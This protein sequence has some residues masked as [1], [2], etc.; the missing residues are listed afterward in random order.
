MCV[1]HINGRI[2]NPTGVKGCAQ[3][4]HF[5]V[6]NWM[7]A[8]SFLFLVATFFASTCLGSDQEGLPLPQRNKAFGVRCPPAMC[9]IPQGFLLN[10]RDQVFGIHFID[11]SRGWIVG[12][13]G[14]ALMTTDG[15]RSWQRKTISEGIFYDI[16]FIGE[17]GWIVGESGLIL[18]TNDGGESWHRQPCN[19]SLS[20]MCVRFLDRSKGFAVGADGTILRTVDGGLSWKI[21]DFDW[22]SFL[23]MELLDAG[24]LSI[25]LYDIIFINKT[26]GWIV[27]DSGT[28]LHSEDGGRKWRIAHVGL[29]P[30]LYSISF[31]N[32]KE[33]WAVGQNGFSL[34]TSDGGKTWKRVILEKENS[35][36]KIRMCQNYGIIVGDQATIIE[37]ND[38]GKTWDKV[39]TDLDPPYPWLADAWILPSNSAKVLSVGMGII[40]KTGIIPKK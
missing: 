20:L 26:S 15:G 30:H 39:A 35:L 27:G 38:G 31:V 4:E 22:M 34:K 33:G 40:L 5:T 14:L 3:K 1:A 37:T 7:A 28:I 12:G 29:L 10:R 23:P 16:F 2:I 18:H 36:Y 25:N 17:K 8:I 32:D 9:I 21:V 19:V 13:A 6:N 24:I 11:G